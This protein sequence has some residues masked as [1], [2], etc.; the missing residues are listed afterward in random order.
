M[1]YVNEF[2]ENEIIINKSRFIALLFPVKDAIEIT[3][4]IIFTKKKYPKATHYTT[5]YI[6]GEKGETGGSSDDGEPS[7]T[8]GMPIFEILKK[9]QVTNVLCVVVRY[10]GGVKLGAGG[11]I[12]AYS[13]SASEVL[14]IASLYEKK[15]K[16]I[17]QITVEYSL[18]ESIK[19]LVE[20]N[21][22]ITDQQF[23]ENV[24]IHFYS[25][26]NDT[27]FLNDYYHLVKLDEI[28]SQIIKIF[29]QN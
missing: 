9:Y 27:L 17:F 28:G 6:L 29:K 10:Y 11:L 15:E 25:N 8:A 12:R 24:L 26:N 7:G 19:K 22:V 13:K 14:K 16:K 18:Y 23:L 4:K 5:G 21:G 3:E 1:Y 20:E 2:I